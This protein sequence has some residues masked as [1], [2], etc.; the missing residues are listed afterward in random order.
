MPFASSSPAAIID[1]TTVDVYVHPERQRRRSGTTAKVN[2]RTHRK[3]KKEERK[4][5]RDKRQTK[6]SHPVRFPDPPQRATVLRWSSDLQ[7]VTETPR[8]GKKRKTRCQFFFSTTGERFTEYK[9]DV[10]QREAIARGISLI[11]LQPR[12]AFPAHVYP[13]SIQFAHSHFGIFSV[14]FSM[15]FIL[16]NEKCLVVGCSRH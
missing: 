15:I 7:R 11:L 10:S 9:T 6:H 4:K 1:S 14:S 8:H 13:L 2:I 3:Q 16:L 5:K 12:S